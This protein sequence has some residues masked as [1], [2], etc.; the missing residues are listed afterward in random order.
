[1]LTV[2]THFSIP[3]ESMRHLRFR[4]AFVPL[5]LLTCFFVPLFFWCYHGPMQMWKALE[6]PWPS[7]LI[8]LLT[9]F[10]ASLLPLFPVSWIIRGRVL[11]PVGLFFAQHACQML[12]YFFLGTTAYEIPGA[13][14]SIFSTSGLVIILNTVGI[15]VMLIV[16][17]FN[18]ALAAH[19]KLTLPPLPINWSHLDEGAT[20]MLR[21]FSIVCAGALACPMVLTGSIPALSSDVTG[22]RLLLV[23]SDAGRA[24][25]HA[26]TGLLPFVIAGLTVGI[27]RKPSRL[28]GWDGVAVLLVIGMQL[29]TSNRLP[30]AFAMIATV[31]LISLQF[32]WPRWVLISALLFYIFNFVFLGGLMGAMRSDFD[33][34]MHSNW[35]TASFEEAYLGNTLIDVRDAAWVLG[36]WDFEPIL[37][38]SYLG[39]AVSFMP[40]GLFPEKKDWHIGMISIRMVGWP[41]DAHFGLRITLFGEAFLNFGFL[42]VIFLA[43]VLGILFGFLLRILHLSATTPENSF[44]RNLTYLILIQMIFSLPNTGEAFISWVYV[45]A[46]SLLIFGAKI[47]ASLR[48]PA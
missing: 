45:V 2:P 33:K 26:G 48:A 10:N 37:G 5:A 35:I 31:C 12:S 46:L 43:A 23:S 17:E 1:M 13:A 36:S 41:E 4:Y 25:Y 14:S 11:D 18:Y 29:L 32:K 22:D 19:A 39:G 3:V 21:I 38:K 8:G 20:T 27:L 40:S 30:L 34:F 28:W 42:G 9:I 15:M 16:L 44:L 24:V 7:N 47:L 6:F